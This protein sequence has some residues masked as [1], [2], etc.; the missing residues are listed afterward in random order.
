MSKVFLIFKRFLAKRKC[1]NSF[2]LS[3]KKSNGKDEVLARRMLLLVLCSIKVEED[4][5]F[6][7][8]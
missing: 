8:V 2:L 7:F 3:R 5:D 4:V 1:R 6:A